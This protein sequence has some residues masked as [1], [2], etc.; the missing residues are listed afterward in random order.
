MRTIAKNPKPVD[1][2]APK[3][4][5]AGVLQAQ[6]KFDGVTAFRV[7]EIMAIYQLG[8][9]AAVRLLVIDGLQARHTKGGAA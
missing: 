4:P 2:L 8:P 7:R 3:S 1:L 6:V 9:A 5:G